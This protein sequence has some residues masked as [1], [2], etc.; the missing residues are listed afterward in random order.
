MWVKGAPPGRPNE[1][2][3]ITGA[4][5]STKAVVEIVNEGIIELR[6]LEEQ[7]K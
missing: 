4:T 2:E 7:V 6:R 1:V 3:V 5:I